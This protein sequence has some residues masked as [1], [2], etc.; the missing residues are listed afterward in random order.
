MRKDIPSLHLGFWT[1]VFYLWE[2]QKQKVINNS[3]HILGKTTWDINVDWREGNAAYNAK[4]SKPLL[5]QI[6]CDFRTPWFQHLIYPFPLVMDC[7]YSFH[8]IMW[9]AQA[10]LFHRMKFTCA[11]VMG[12]VLVSLS[13][14]Q[15]DI[16]P[17]KKRKLPA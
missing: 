13:R 7:W 16:S 17:R 12:S 15:G 11:I 14:K 2:K 8:L 5:M 4:G 3:M 10:Y 6:I 1:P 9:C